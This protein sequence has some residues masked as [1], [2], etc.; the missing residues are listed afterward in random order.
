MCVLCRFF[1]FFLLEQYQKVIHKC[2]LALAGRLLFLW[3][4]DLGRLVFLWNLN[5]TAKPVFL[6]NLDLAGNFD[7]AGK[8]VFL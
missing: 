2:K 4:L 6:W 1:L 8:L 7:L 3:N 5:L